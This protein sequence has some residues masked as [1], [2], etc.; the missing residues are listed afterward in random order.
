[1]IVKTELIKDQGIVKKLY[2]NGLAELSIGNYL[3]YS[4]ID[5]VIEDEF[6]TPL[7]FYNRDVAR[8]SKMLNLGTGSKSVPFVAW[9][10]W[11][12]KILYRGGTMT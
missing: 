3:G 7:I 12:D 9:R 5:I 10:K 11:T 1:M 6:G 4:P 8:C 2:E